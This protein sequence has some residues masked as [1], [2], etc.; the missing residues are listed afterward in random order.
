M[1]ATAM[2]NLV[3]RPD[4]IG[5]ALHHVSQ[6]LHMVSK[7]LS[8]HDAASDANIAVVVAM[9]QF[10][11]HQGEYRRGAI[12]LEG[13]LK[14]VELRGGISLLTGYKPSLTQKIFRYVAV[15]VD[16]YFVINRRN[17]ADLEFALYLGTATRFSIDDLML[18]SRAILDY[19]SQNTFA[20]VNTPLFDKLSA[21]LQ[22][23][24]L[25]IIALSWQLNVISTR[26]LQKLN[27]YKFHD[28]IILL[29]YRLIDTSPL[30][31]FLPGL[32]NAVHLG[33]AAFLLT[34]LRRLDYKVSEM[35]L[36][37]KLITSAVRQIDEQESSQELLLWLLFI[38]NASI[39][40]SADDLWILPIA[41][42]TTKTLD[43][44]TW[45]DVRHTLARWPWVNTLHDMHGEALWCRYASDLY[46]HIAM[47]NKMVK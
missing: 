42:R 46:Q 36:L 44:H 30:C 43:L 38:G 31:G 10:E 28:T 14:M 4:D 18:G 33:L 1:S 21:D 19:D 22:E 40:T 7:R 13:L 39:F 3:A 27:N 5:E 45:Q 11:R 12:H 37:Y 47:P 16:F 15:A 25:D 20:V 35:P 24:L 2:N 9:I 8:G 26:R 17:R 6:A 34:F 41:K 23:L 29:G 32:A